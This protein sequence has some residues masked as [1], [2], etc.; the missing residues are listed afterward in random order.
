M[1]Y[2]TSFNLL[3]VDVCCEPP[4]L[5]RNAEIV[6]MPPELIIGS[7]IELNCFYGYSLRGGQDIIYLT[8]DANR[9]WMPYI[10]EGCIGKRP[11]AY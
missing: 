5:I 9:N 3:H 10:K 6:R 2:I 11:I 8:C 4:P 7:E 1:I